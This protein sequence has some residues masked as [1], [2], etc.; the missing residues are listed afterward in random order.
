MKRFVTLIFVLICSMSMLSGCMTSNKNEQLPSSSAPTLDQQ[1]LFYGEVKIPD[2]MFSIITFYNNYLVYLTLD[3]NNQAGISRFDVNTGD[4]VE[5]CK[6]DDYKMNPAN[7]TVLAGKI[8]LNYMANDASRK[9]LEI[10]I[11][12]AVKDTIVAED[13]VTGLAYCAATSESVFSLKHTTDGRSVIERYVPKTKT[14]D[15]FL[16]FESNQTACAISTYGEHLYVLLCDE[17]GEYCIIQ[18]SDDGNETDTWVLPSVS[19]ILLDSQAGFFQVM[20]SA[21]YIMNFSGQSAA[22]HMD[23]TPIDELSAKAIATDTAGSF[24]SYTFFGR[25]SNLDLITYDTNKETLDELQVCKEGT[26]N[27]RYIYSDCNNPQRLLVSLRSTETGVETVSIIS[28][29]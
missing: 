16:I 4:V 17:A 25:G 26:D 20:D 15:I 2:E 28:A 27:I 9:M 23:G 8:Y 18:Y 24:S 7:N 5:I 13:N 11:E 21:F 22:F 3:K 19:D 6:L 12:A 14:N 29:L 1:E 10:D